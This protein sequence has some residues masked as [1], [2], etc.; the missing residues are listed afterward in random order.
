MNSLRLI[1]QI[2]IT[3]DDVHRWLQLLSDRIDALEKVALQI[4]S[5]KSEAQEIQERYWT[6]L[7]SL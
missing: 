7:G 2:Q 3:Q 1:L 6:A 4:G 5:Q